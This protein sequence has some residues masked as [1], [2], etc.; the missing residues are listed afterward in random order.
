METATITTVE[1]AGTVTV[2]LVRLEGS[3]GKLRVPYKII[4]VSA[5]AGSDYKVSMDE[6]IFNDG[7]T[8]KVITVEIIDDQLREIAETFQIQ[9]LDLE[10]QLGQFNFRRLGARRSTVV[11]IIDD[12]GKS[13]KVI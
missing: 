10:P 5:V 2:P 7:E 9:L 8:R 11:S 6:I 3:D 1:N 12:D 13:T 4:D